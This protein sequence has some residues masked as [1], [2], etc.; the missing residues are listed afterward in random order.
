MADQAKGHTLI[1][2][3]KSAAMI[4]TASAAIHYL[5]NVRQQLIS[6][7]PA[8]VAGF[9]QI[10][11]DDRI[12]VAILL[13]VYERLDFCGSGTMHIAFSAEE[14]R[15]LHECRAHHIPT[16]QD[17]SFHSFTNEIGSLLPR[18][19]DY[20]DRLERLVRKPGDHVLRPSLDTSHS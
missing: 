15:L 8:A 9:D 13:K 3:P 16:P 12:K 14:M 6:I 4:A 2:L 17:L 18:R 5:S 11:D 10:L 7:R 1:R 20:L 19:R